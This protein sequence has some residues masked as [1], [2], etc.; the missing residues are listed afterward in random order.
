MS[1]TPPEDVQSPVRGEDSAGMDKAAEAADEGEL[2]INAADAG[3]QASEM[4]SSD[5]SGIKKEQMQHPPAQVQQAKVE[6]AKGK[7]QEQGAEFEDCPLQDQGWLDHQDH[8][9]GSSCP[10]LRQ[11]L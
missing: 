1:A 7:L 9:R 8:G 4:A 11:P 6:S 10:S 3:E 2:A 5:A